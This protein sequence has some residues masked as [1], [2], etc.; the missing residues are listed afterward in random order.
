MNISSIPREENITAE[1]FKAKYLYPH[2]PVVLQNFS[3]GWKA[4]EK[5]TYDYFKR[6]AGEE[7]VKLYGRWVDHEP[8]RIEMPPAKEVPFSEYLSL[9]EKNEKSDLRIFLFNLFKIRPD[10]L[11][12]FTFPDFSDHYLRDYPYM[13]FGAAE[14]DVRLHYDI[15]LSHVFISQ[16]AGTK[17]IT[18][19]EQSE[20]KFLYK[21]PFTTHSAVDMSAIDLDKYPTVAYAKGYQTDLK[22][23][24]T[25]FMPSGIWHHVQY[26]DASFSL[27]LRALAD[28]SIDKLK[29]VYNV[30]V[31]RKLDEYMNKFYKNKWSDYKLNTA[32]SRATEILDERERVRIEGK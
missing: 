26:L 22:P 9:L 16:F 27:S 19:F 28:S 3:A 1:E 7:K 23:G 13:F 21:L 10:L 32:M 18:L 20:T 29:G 17:R 6:I 8:T 4:N 12:D 14:S 24:E 2:K 11:N 5:W 15:D 30:F 25:L 31:V